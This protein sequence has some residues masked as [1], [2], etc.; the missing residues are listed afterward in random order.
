MEVPV[1]WQVL[2]GMYRFGYFDVRWMMDARSLDGK[3]II[4]INDPNV[5][6]YVLPGRH[7]GPAGHAAIK[8]E[9]YQ[10]VV[11]N[12]RE[13]QPYAE[14]YGKHRF[15][16]VCKSWTPRQSAWTPA[17]P[18]DWR[19]EAGARASEA[20]VTFDCA[21]S[22]GPR[23]VTVYARNTMH[24]EGLW[25]VDPI[26]SILGT[27]EAMPL[28][29]SM[30]QHMIDSWQENQQWKDYQQQMAYKGLAQI[31]AGF[32]Q[33]MQ[34][35]QAYHQQ[36]E[37]A[38][39]RQVAHFES[40][41]DAQAQQVSGWGETLTGLTTVRDSATGTEFQVFSGPKANYYTNG[42]G[43]T[44]NSSLSPGL[45]FHQVSVVGP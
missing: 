5:P 39:N 2:G 12:F 10:M 16:N 13:A 4:R 32:Q 9:M 36:R 8:P 20:T 30:T 42:D 6:P 26:I 35:M 23:V 18:L 7:S 34:Q 21:T 22:D 40:Q 3:I 45:G 43:V 33:F 24:S 41:Q 19:S 14:N 29:E 1:G 15:S 38:M 28:A 25:Q 37:V 27:P 11:D 31:R 17:M 44:V